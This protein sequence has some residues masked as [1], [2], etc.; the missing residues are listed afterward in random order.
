MGC[1]QCLYLA[2]KN[3]NIDRAVLS[4]CITDDKLIS[5]VNH[6]I[7]ESWITLRPDT[8]TYFTNERLIKM[9]YPK[10]LMI[11]NGKKDSVAVLGKGYPL[12]EKIKEIYKDKPK[13]FIFV[14]HSGGH[15]VP[16][17]V[18]EFF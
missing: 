4:G 16:K 9:I 2:A 10:S 1:Q 3:N 18:M 17:E 15:E 11:V 12:L 5:N 13:N 14:E 8:I 7:K 6:G